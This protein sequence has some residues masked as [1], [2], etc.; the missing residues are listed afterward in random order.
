MST[1]SSV[2][3]L[4]ASALPARLAPSG[5]GNISGKMVRMLARHMLL[6]DA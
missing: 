2:H 5:P 4:A 6:D 3:S 1:A